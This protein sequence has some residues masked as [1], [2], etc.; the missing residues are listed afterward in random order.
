[1]MKELHKK[2][3]RLLRSNRGTTLVEVI[4]TIVI[5]GIVVALSAGILLSGSTLIS[6]VTNRDL[7]TQIAKSVSQLATD[8]INMAKSVTV[9]TP[10][11]LEDALKRDNTLI[12]IGDESG[13]PAAKGR[14]Y[15]RKA[16]TTE[17]AINIFGE[18][19]Y[20]GRSIALTYRVDKVEPDLP[21]AIT[22]ITS[23]HN[24]DELTAKRHRSIQILNAPLIP[25]QTA[26]PAT[27]PPQLPPLQTGEWGDD[28]TA[29][30]LEIS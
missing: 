9:L 19:F 4:L 11:E 29:I 17:P 7:D 22:I 15:F 26:D 8:N 27:Y 5:A 23:V 1:M 25:P 21:K 28:T 30:I 10:A 3:C 24:R 16:G 12:Y 18:V 13:A 14:L 20:H 6:D 2:I